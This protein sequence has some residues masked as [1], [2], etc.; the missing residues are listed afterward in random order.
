MGGSN[1]VGPVIFER[2]GTV[3][4][5]QSQ[6]FLLLNSKIYNFN[7]IS[8]PP[9]IIYNFIGYKM[10]HINQAQDMNEPHYNL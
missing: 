2:L 1:A 5:P 4:L 6:S 10:I 3:G 7:I 8:V 9:I